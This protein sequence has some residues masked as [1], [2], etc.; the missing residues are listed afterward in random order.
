[1]ASVLFVLG[2]ALV[3]TL[4]AEATYSATASIVV[5][6]TDVEAAAVP[7][8][9]AANN[10]LA[11]TYSRLVGTTDH[12]ALIPEVPGR[13]SLDLA[14]LLGASPIPDTPI[15]VVTASGSSADAAVQ[16]ADEAS[17]ALISLVATLNDPSSRGEAILAE[18]RV[19]AEQLAVANVELAATQSRLSALGEAAAPAATAAA[20]VEV[21]QAQAAF[22]EAQLRADTL[23]EAYRNSQRAVADGDLLRPVSAAASTGSNRASAL[24][25]ALAAGLLGGG[26]LGVS[27]AWLLENRRAI[28]SSVA[29]SDRSDIEDGGGATDRAKQ[30]EPSRT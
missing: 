6:R 26:L 29:P 7:G 30:R 24:A 9:T 16:L 22:A 20:R 12:V 15:I 3:A 4:R 2:A 10:T 18:Y 21:E 28:G 8:F 25:L 5:G 19:A 1:V 23:A 17:A 13:S 11:A 14:E 27:L